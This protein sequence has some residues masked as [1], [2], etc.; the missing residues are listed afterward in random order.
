MNTKKTV[1]VKELLNIGRG[2]RDYPPVWCL[3]KQMSDDNIPINQ[4]NGREGKASYFMIT[5]PNSL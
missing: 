2:G 3:G 5:E 1:E 4:L